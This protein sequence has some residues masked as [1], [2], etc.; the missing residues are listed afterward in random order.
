MPECTE[1]SPVSAQTLAAMLQTDVTERMRMPVKP[2]SFADERVLCYLID[3]RGGDRSLPANFLG[4]CFYHTGCPVY[5][6]LLI[7]VCG[8]NSQSD[9]VSGLTGAETELLQ[10]WL[11]EQFSA[12][13]HDA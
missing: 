2:A 6:D 11:R 8:E 3:A 1:E 9:A 5:G 4:T 10:N 12:Y 13:L 7:G